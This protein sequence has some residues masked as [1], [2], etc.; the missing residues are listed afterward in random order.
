MSTPV[1]NVDARFCQ[2]LSI[3]TLDTAWDKCLKPM[4]KIVSVLFVILVAALG[5]PSCV[6]TAWLLCCAT[7]A[8]Q[9]AAGPEPILRVTLEPKRVVVGQ[10]VTLRIELLA[11]NY[12]TAPPEFPD[13][14]VRNAVSRPLGNINLSE[15]K[16]GATYAG[17]RH[18]IAIHPQEA[19]RYAIAPD[20]IAFTYA[21]EPPAGRQ[22]KVTLP[23][24]AFEAFIPAAAQSLDPF[25]AADGLAVRQAVDPPSGDRKVGDAVTRTITIEV[26]GLPAMV[27]P[28]PSF[29]AADGLAVYPDQ[30]TLQDHTDQRSGVLTGTRVDRASYILQKPGDY[31]LPAIEIAWWNL[32]EQKV[33]RVRV[34]AV[35]L[36]VLANPTL[37]GSAQGGRSAAMSWRA[38]VSTILAHW[39]WIVLVA[40]I[41]AGLGWIAPRALAYAKRWY[42][43]RQA[44]Y[45][46]SEAW[47]FARFR[48]TARRGDARA[49]YFALEGWLARF[50][51]VAPAHTIAALGAAAQ[52]PV[53]D[54]ELALIEAQLFSAGADRG[55]WSPASLLRRVTMARRRLRGRH[56]RSRRRMP[57]LAATLN[58]GA[59][60]AALRALRPVAR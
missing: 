10:P 22:G 17:I 19:G 54:R 4:K 18:E 42:A 48:Q 37:P 44:A 60:G 1:I 30:P 53:L 55:V 35:T 50:G 36:H 59:S 11:P 23:A 33:E 21:A 43:G 12:F 15:Q 45:L 58:P 38:W 20:S 25:I 7:A 47:S 2:F 46:Q 57:S 16:D 24:L 56:A 14:Q 9:P 27:L 6:I 32:A 49:T 3:A 39:P 28:P 5:A 26:Q 40:A 52:D 13:I 29:P 8:A 41:L 34:D 51:P 31:A